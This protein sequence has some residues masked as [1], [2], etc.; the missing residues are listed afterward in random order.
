MDIQYNWKKRPTAQAAKK[1]L[2]MSTFADGFAVDKV[3]NLVEFFSQHDAQK[4]YR[5]LGD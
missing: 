4:R 1:N 2:A 3:A 5:S